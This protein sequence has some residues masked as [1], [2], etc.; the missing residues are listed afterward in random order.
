MSAPLGRKER[1]SKVLHLI[2]MKQDFK[3]LDRMNFIR[4]CIIGLNNIYLG[5]LIFIRLFSWLFCD[6]T[7]CGPPP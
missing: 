6:I 2:C 7:E 3:Y 1:E 4:L 5:C